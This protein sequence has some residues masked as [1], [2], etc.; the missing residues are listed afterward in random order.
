[1]PQ[2][3]ASHGN[4]KPARGHDAVVW[5]TRRLLELILVL[6]IGAAGVGLVLDTELPLGFALAGIALMLAW[7]RVTLPPPID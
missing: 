1:V 3:A 7:W 2:T 5:S 6:V 4:E